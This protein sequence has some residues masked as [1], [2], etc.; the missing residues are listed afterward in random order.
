[1]SQFYQAIKP[2]YNFLEFTNATNYRPVPDNW[3]IVIA[4]VQG[5]TQA[6]ESGKYKLVNM[7]GASSIAAISNAMNSIDIPFVFGGDG[8]TAL[9]PN[10]ALEKVSS[11]LR[12][13]RSQS[14]QQFKINLRVGIVPIKELYKLNHRI[15]VAKFGLPGGPCIAFLKGSGVDFA[16]SLVKA[17]DYILTDGPIQD[18]SEALKGL[19]CRWAPLKNT[20]GL[21][22]SLLIKPQNKEKGFEVLPE[23]LQKIDTLVDLSSKK[24]HPIKEHQMNAGN[25]I[26]S[27]GIESSFIPKNSKYKIL[28]YIFATY[29]MKILNLKK[30]NIS[31]QNYIADNPT[32]SD[33]RKYDETL[34]MVIDCSPEM[35][36]KII[37]YLKQQYS[38]K[39]IFYGHSTSDSALLTCFV[40]SMEKGGHIHFVDGNDGGY[41]LAAKEIKSQMKSTAPTPSPQHQYQ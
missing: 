34:R 9:I 30:D 8:S 20:Q 13:V 7:I 21:I 6:I 37:Q 22:L 5:S 31:M 32:H 23:I 24:T 27:A 36:D 17:G 14:E 4:D 16:E 3:H 10:E 2:F 12:A 18:I 1:M 33:F 39:K 25:A 28:M 38:T 19:S 15:E 11:A 41:T 35:K 29:I 40:P 26:L